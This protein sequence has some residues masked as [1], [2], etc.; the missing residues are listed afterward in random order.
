MPVR[1]EFLNLVVPV[2]RVQE[3]YP[4]G[5]SGFI[6]DHAKRLGRTVWFS[7]S[8]VRAGGAMD[9]EMADGLMQRWSDLGF[10][11]TEVVED[12]KQWKDFL[13]VDAFGRC[14]YPCPW[15]MID[16]AVAWLR[17]TEMGE[18]VGRDSFRSKC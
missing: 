9:P 17:G 12:R 5:W 14:L 15:I 13:L 8:L 16:G 10:T 6:A 4:G 3:L 7:S 18:V 11:A 2:A 1:L